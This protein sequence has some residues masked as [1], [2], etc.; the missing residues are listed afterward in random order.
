MYTVRVYL[1]QALSVCGAVFIMSIW[2]YSR[3]ILRSSQWIYFAT[4]KSAP[5][6]GITNAL[7]RHLRS[8]HERRGVP[9][10][11]SGA[12]RRMN[13]TSG[14]TTQREI[15]PRRVTKY[16]LYLL[17]PRRKLLRL[18]AGA[19]RACKRNALWTGTALVFLV[20]R[21]TFDHLFYV[22]QYADLIFTHLFTGTKEITQW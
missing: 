21:L 20:Q 12:W 16:M 7:S 11:V 3:G 2:H 10:L 5:N 6:T 22:L 18:C 4:R 14:S 15:I 8:Q 9:S 19:R 1:T 13:S 17:T